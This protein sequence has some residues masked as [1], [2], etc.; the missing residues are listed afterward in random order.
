M[1]N[2]EIAWLLK[3]KYHGQKTE[4]FLTDCAR[5]EAGEPLAYLIGSTPFLNCTIHLD[6]KPLIPR[7]ETEFWVERAI[8]AIKLACSRPFL[9]QKMESRPHALHILDLCAGSGAIGVAVAQAIPEAHVTFGE[10]DATHLP[11][12]LKNL[13]EN[14]IKYDSEQY[15]V[16][17][18]N[19]FAAFSPEQQFDVILSN[20][21]YIDAAARTVDESVTAHEPHLALFGGTDGLKLIAKIIADAPGYLTP[22]GALWLEHEPFQSEAIASFATQHGFTI[23]TY[24]DQYTILRYSVLRRVVPK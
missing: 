4:S 3:E 20:P 11:T 10:I 12:I 7:P 13:T 15:R 23:T 5:L 16:I 22:Q 17:E 19:L 21:P 24:P 1:N 18:S 2:Q 9:G 8:D 14:T 6:S